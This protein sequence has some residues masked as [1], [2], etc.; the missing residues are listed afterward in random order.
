VP[1]DFVDP[2]TARAAADGCTAIV[3]CAAT[4]GP[5]LASAERVNL[6]GTLSMV[7]AARAN[8]DL[9]FIHLST[10]SVYELGTSTDIDES[11]PLATSGSDYSITKAAA[12]R[13]VLA[14]HA[15]GLPTTLLRPGA[16]FGAHPTSAWGAKIAG[17]IRAGGFALHRSRVGTLPWVH[18]SSVVAAALG[19]LQRPA[20]CGRIYNLVDGHLTMRDYVETVRSWLPGSPPATATDDRSRT[21]VSTVHA[22]RFRPELGVAP[23]P[24]LA[25]ALAEMAQWWQGRGGI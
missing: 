6:H 3:H 16:I 1:G 13:A 23:A 10:I 7:A 4:V 18:I 15:T 11:S 21:W 24:P 8:G 5:D 12:D 9:R 17:T 22:E 2:P 20:T 25:A 14:A 19:A